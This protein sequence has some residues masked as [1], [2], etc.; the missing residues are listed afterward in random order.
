MTATWPF[1]ESTETFATGRLTGAL[2]D[3]LTHHVSILET[4]R[5]SCRLAQGRPHNFTRTA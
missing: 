1:D 5:E 4:N 3:R 2:P